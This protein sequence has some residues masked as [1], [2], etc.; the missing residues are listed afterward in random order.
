MRE[1]SVIL[2]LLAFG[3]LAGAHECGWGVVTLLQGDLCLR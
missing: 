1:L 2:L 3:L